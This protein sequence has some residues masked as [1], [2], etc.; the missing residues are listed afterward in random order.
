MKRATPLT[1]AEARDLEA[2]D[3]LPDWGYD[4]HDRTK[5]GFEENPFELLAKGSDWGR[6]D[7]RLVSLDYSA[8]VIDMDLDA[9]LR[10]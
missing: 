1:D 6:I 4:P 2:G 9:A 10:G 8:P 5:S 3:Q 7:G